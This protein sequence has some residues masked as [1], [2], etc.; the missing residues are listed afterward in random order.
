[1]IYCGQ[2]ARFHSRDTPGIASFVNS[3]SLVHLPSDLT[4]GPSR[5]ERRTDE[6][7][8]PVA[9][10]RRRFSLNRVARAALTRNKLFFT[11]LQPHRASRLHSHVRHSHVASR[12]NYERTIARS[13]RSKSPFRV[14]TDSQ[15][16][17]DCFSL[18]CPPIE[19][20]KKK[21]LA[22]I[23]SRSKCLGQATAGDRYRCCH[24]RLE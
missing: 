7:Y 5:P 19:Q 13:Y 16:K 14:R 12:S 2:P 10:N 18:L 23:G 9:E 8:S 6:K 21:S 15:S 1:M 20:K 17:E 4:Q 3:R 24:Q 11:L 22:S